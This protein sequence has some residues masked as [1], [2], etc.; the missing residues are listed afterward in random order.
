MKRQLILLRKPFNL[1][2][3]TSSRFNICVRKFMFTT[4]SFL[5]E[6]S[7]NLMDDNSEESNNW[8]DLN[9]IIRCR[10]TTAH[11][12]CHNCGKALKVVPTLNSNFFLLYELYKFFY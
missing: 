5:K 12:N 1:A 10:L 11:N 8:Y 9:T 6:S 4:T 3:V 7:S 2:S